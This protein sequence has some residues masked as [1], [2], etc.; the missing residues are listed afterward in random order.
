[1]SPGPHGRV[2]R[3]LVAVT[4][5]LSLVLGLAM[6]AT[7]VRWWQLRGEN[8]DPDF[9]PPT[10]VTSVSSSPAPATGRCSENPCNYLLLGS[11]SREGL[12]PEEQQQYGTDDQIG[13]ENRADTIMLIHT[14]P[15]LQK[16]I[17]LSFPRDLWVEIPGHGSDKI[18]AAFEGGVGGGGPQLMAQ[19]V[20]NLTGLRIDH[21]LYVDLAGFQG[22]VDT[23]GGVTMCPPAYLADPATGRIQDPLTGLDIEPGC[24]V[25]DGKTALAFVRTRHL[26]CDNIPDFSRIGRQQQFL[27]AVITQMLRPSKIA[28]AP[29]LVGPVL[30][31]MRRDARFLPGDLVYLVGEMRGLSTGAAEF[32][33]VPG[34]AGWE[35]ELS[36]V[37]MDPSAEQIFE[38]IRAGEPIGDA[39]T[40]LVNTP[41]SPANVEVAVID[42]V[43]GGKASQVETVLENSGFAVDPELWAAWRTPK[44]VEGPAAIVYRP[45]SEAE[46]SV[47]GAY[48]PGVPLVASERLRGTTV[49]V[50]VTAAYEPQ[51]PGA[52]EQQC[53]VA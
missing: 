51:E 18:N 22:V 10:P 2:T 1:M 28:Q 6:S 52:G 27:R 21:Y 9:T 30:D 13:G 19:T 34:V 50:L 35:G 8:V 39:G 15:N 17:I 41:I 26:P 47:V 53:P 49:A 36:V 3:V 45:G 7:A 14:D 20:A 25:M 46:A 44:G 12:T 33:A 43:S 16:A 38:A 4:A 48:L 32:R 5:S 37:H 29:A 42:G 24:Q 11:D 40:E 31:N 23:L